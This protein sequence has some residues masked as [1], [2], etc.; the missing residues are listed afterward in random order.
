MNRTTLQGLIERRILINYRVEP[1]VLKNILPEPFRPKIFQNYGIAGLCLFRISELRL[2]GLPTFMG[3]TTE[4]VS[5]RIAVEWDQNGI[6]YEGIYIPRRN[7]SSY[8]VAASGGKIFPGVHH[9]SN[10]SSR[11]SN[12]YYELDVY[13][14]NH[15]HLSLLAKESAHFARGS[16]FKN[17]SSAVESLV[18]HSLEYSPRYQKRVFDGIEFVAENRK[19]QPLHIS[20]IQ[21]DFFE[22]ESLFPKGSVF[23]DHALLMKNIY[24]QWHSCPEILSPRPMKFM[25]EINF[26]VTDDR[27]GKIHNG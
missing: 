13:N 6:R 14:R 4:N 24:A 16:V 11:E 2:K 10:F 20:Q 26:P 19:V 21:S 3:I 8:I 1:G 7:T 17:L 9:L 18:N 27:E 22:N 12:G 25:P 5:H 15:L 23:F